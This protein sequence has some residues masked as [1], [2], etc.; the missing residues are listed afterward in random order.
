MPRFTQ[1]QNLFIELYLANGMNATAAA[2]EAGYSEKT[3]EVIGFE[4]LNKPQIK[5]EIQR[6]IN[7]RLDNIEQLQY[8][9]IQECIKLAFY[10]PDRSSPTYAVDMAAKASALNLIGRYLQFA[11][12][13]GGSGDI[14]LTITDD[15]AALL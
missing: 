7:E 10:T 5:A 2:R 6:R 13:Q 12:Q 4:N 9:W 15:D 8:L 1:K 3:A 14:V 11:N